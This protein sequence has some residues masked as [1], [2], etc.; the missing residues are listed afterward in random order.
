MSTN[1]WM[2][3]ALFL[4]LL[5]A[6]VKPLGAYMAAV[7][8]GRLRWLGWLEDWT[9]KICGVDASREQSWQKYAQHW[10][11]FHAW[12]FLAVLGIL[13]TQQWHPW[14]PQVFGNLPFHTLLDAMLNQTALAMERLAALDEARQAALDTESERLRNS[15][16]SAVSHDLRT[17]LTRIAGAASTLIEQEDRLPPEK[18]RELLRAIEEE[19]GRLN[20][21]VTNLLEMTRLEDGRVNIR[22]DLCSIEEIVGSTLDALEGM[23]A[24]RA[25]LSHVGKDLPEVEGDPLLLSQALQNLIENAVKYSPPNTPIEVRAERAGDAIRLQ[26]LDLG[27]GLAAGTETK[28][29]EKFY[30][31]VETSVNR[32]VGLGLAIVKSI[33]QAH[34]GKACAANRASAYAR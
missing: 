33:A 10:L 14:N 21:L 6:A 27:P 29:F 12:G 26:V 15:L 4:L 32:G 16:L 28:V 20:R 22:R 1:A 8:E 19:S 23:T 30:R 25:I 3:I 11:W 18:R 9:L 5:V 24:G 17:P 34:G 2:Q 13:M 7:Y 31:G